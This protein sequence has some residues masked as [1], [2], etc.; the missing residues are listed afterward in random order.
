M[1]FRR[2]KSTVNFV[3]NNQITTASRIQKLSTRMTMN[4]FAK[5]RAMRVMRGTVVYVPTCPLANVPKASHLIFTCQLAKACQFFN[6]NVPK[7]VLFFNFVCQKACQILTI[8]QKN[9]KMVHKMMFRQLVVQN[10]S[11]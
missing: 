10:L 3:G 4:E 6:L 8:F 11:T 5:S 1:Q 9:L 7:N 2:F